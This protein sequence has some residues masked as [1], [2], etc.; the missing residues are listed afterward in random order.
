MGGRHLLSAASH[1]GLASVEGLFAEGTGQQDPGGLRLPNGRPLGSGKGLGTFC[2]KLKKILDPLA[3]LARASNVHWGKKHEN[4]AP[5]PRTAKLNTG[6]SRA[7]RR[8]QPGPAGRHQPCGT[9]SS[10][11]DF[12]KGGGWLAPEGQNGEETKEKEKTMQKKRRVGKENRT[13]GNRVAW[14]LS[15]GFQ[16]E[17]LQVTTKKKFIR[18]PQR[19]AG[20]PSWPALGRGDFKLR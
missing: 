2:P 3:C 1:T 12:D 5:G 13:K 15:S 9:D 4:A 7:R 10:N 20:G 16:N 19:H 11:A 14:G 18:G 17:G 6:R 8:R